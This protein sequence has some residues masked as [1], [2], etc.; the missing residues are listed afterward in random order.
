[1][2]PLQKLVLRVGLLALAGLWGC[3]SGES[4]LIPP[5]PSASPSANRVFFYVA[6]ATDPQLG[7]NGGRVS[8]YQIGADGLLPGSPFASVAAVNPRRLIKHPVLPVM[9][10]ATANQI[11]AFDISGGSLNSLC[12]GGG[13][14]PPCATDPRFG[15]NPFDMTIA[16][17]DLG[18]Y[19]LYVSEAGNGQNTGLQTRLS[20]YPLGS[21]GELP[22]N[23]TS[24]VQDPDS[25]R[26]E[27]SSMFPALGYAY[28]S[29]RSAAIIIRYLL[30]ADGNLTQP[31]TSPTPVGGGTPTPTPSPTPLGV[32]PSPSPT[33]VKGFGPGRM[34][35][36][37][38]P[39]CP[40]PS[41]GTGQPMIYVV[42]QNQKRMALFPL[43]TPIPSQP[44]T[45][46]ELP[47]HPLSE[48]NTR[49]IYNAMV[50]DPCATRIY[51]AAFND[52]QIDYY[53]LNSDG[54]FNNATEGSTFADTSTYPTGLAYI[55]YDVLG[56]G[57]QTTILVSLGGVN[58]VDAYAVQSDGTLPLK[59]FS[60]TTPID[61]T[62]PAD[63]LAYI[64]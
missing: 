11:L 47:D 64:P 16:Q 42:A 25:L 6:E 51:A 38:F 33:A 26:F 32:T 1:M 57:P 15:S 40:S 41:P 30:L 12:S 62:F 9:Y 19:F 3:P 55:Q 18:D 49:G 36:L 46:G 27:S 28:I 10:V 45:G 44:G 37:T 29:D 23:A 14:A 59:P 54:T 61:G 39:V 56:Q 48:S 60:S 4:K 7:V 5:A 34:L 13:L 8:A 22:A 50:T 20:A 35:P 43:G 17:N 53:Q 58:R 2:F 52:G 31:S 21:N 24:Q 63:I